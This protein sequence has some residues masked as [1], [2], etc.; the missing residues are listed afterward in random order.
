LKSS[1]GLKKNAIE[2]TSITNQYCPFGKTRGAGSWYTIYE[3]H[4]FPVVKGVSSNPSFFINQPM[5]QWEK[6]IYVTN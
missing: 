6:D 1:Q 4:H 3:Y 2:T 5:D